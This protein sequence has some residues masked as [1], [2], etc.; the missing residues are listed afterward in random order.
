MPSSPVRWLLFGRGTLPEARRIGDLL[1]VETVGGLLLVGTAL[2]AIVWANS[3]W[4]A[5]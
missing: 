3:P 5:L 1:R 4:R 2:I